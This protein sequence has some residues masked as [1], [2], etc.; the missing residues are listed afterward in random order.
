MLSTAAGLQVPVIPLSE[1][2]VN[3]GTV[4]PSQI[5]IEVP[6]LKPGTILGLTV[7]K[8]VTGGEH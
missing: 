8:N 6:K 3:A 4:P 7:T 5:F 2:F 1:V